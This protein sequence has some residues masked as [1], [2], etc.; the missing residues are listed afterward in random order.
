MGLKMRCLLPEAFALV[1]RSIEFRAP[2]CNLSAPACAVRT[3]FLTQNDHADPSE[4]ELEQLRESAGV[5]L[6]PGWQRDNE[7]RV[8]A[9][10]LAAEQPSPQVLRRLEH[11]GS[12]AVEPL[13]NLMASGRIL[14]ADRIRVTHREGSRLLKSIREAEALEAWG[15]R[16]ALLRRSV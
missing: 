9:V 12:L 16:C 14:R 10:A 6:Y 11:E 7:T 15:L 13:S 2:I 8:P 1:S 5:T 4:D 3:D